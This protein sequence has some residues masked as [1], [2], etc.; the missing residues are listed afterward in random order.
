MDVNKKYE[1]LILDY[2]SMIEEVL[3]EI[4][5]VISKESFDAIKHHI[6]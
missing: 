4:E 6:K 3:E 2:K 1:L 5:N